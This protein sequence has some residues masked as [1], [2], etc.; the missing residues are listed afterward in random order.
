MARGSEVPVL[1]SCPPSRLQRTCSV[2]Q[3]HVYI[4]S[5]CRLYS[6]HKPLRRRYE[7]MAWNDDDNPPPGMYVVPPLLAPGSLH[8]SRVRC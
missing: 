4:F 5:I 7:R 8:P 1:L 2:S 6:L 3:T